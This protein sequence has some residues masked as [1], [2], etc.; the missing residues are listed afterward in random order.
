LVFSKTSAQ[1]R[2]ISPRSPRALYFNDD[3]YVGWVRGGPFLEIS[4]ADPVV[5]AAFYAI[6]QDPAIPPRPTRDSGQCLQCHESGRTLG[7]PGHLT[8]SVY[9]AA[10][11]Q[12]L[13][14]L[15]TIDVDQHA[16]RR[17]IWRLVRDGGRD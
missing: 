12:P 11:G 17:A 4:T 10:D 8:R 13:F 9:P 14:Q 7:M 15:G 1:F 16:H 5:G 6:A 2:L 3:V